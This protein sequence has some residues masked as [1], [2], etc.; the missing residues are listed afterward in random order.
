MAE[1]CDVGAMNVP[2]PAN[3]N[4]VDALEELMEAQNESYILGLK[5]KLRKHVV[6]GIHENHSKPRDRL[7]HV[8]LE[9]EQTDPRSTWRLIVAALRSP[10]MKLCTLADEVESKHLGGPTGIIR[11]FVLIGHTIFGRNIC[12]AR[13]A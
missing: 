2:A 3:F 4:A 7:L 6:D 12:H 1:G 13:R 8:L 5:L 10:A 11:M 9:Y